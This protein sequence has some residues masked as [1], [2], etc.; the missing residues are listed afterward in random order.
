MFHRWLFLGQSGSLRGGAICS[1]PNPS[2]DSHTSTL[3]SISLGEGNNNLGEMLGIYWALRYIMIAF[4]ELADPLPGNFPAFVFSDSLCCIC[5]LTD[6]WPA[7]L[8]QSLCWA[9]RCRYNKFKAEHSRFRLYWVKAHAG[10]RD[11]EIAD[12]LAKKCSKYSKVSPG[13]GYVILDPPLF[14]SGYGRVEG[15]IWDIETR[16]W[17]E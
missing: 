16:A 2:N 9:T 4:H 8:E 11:N 12:G 17:E 7:P 10:T 14:Y 15:L 3:F 1:Y 6:N 13:E 5:F